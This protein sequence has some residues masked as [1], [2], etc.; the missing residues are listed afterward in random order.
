MN[1]VKVE[2]KGFFERFWFIISLIVITLIA[3]QC[4]RNQQ[5]VCNFR[6][7]I[8][9]GWGLFLLYSMIRINEF[10][11]AATKRSK[12][13]G[14]MSPAGIC[15]IIAILLLVIDII[16]IKTDI[17]IMH[18]PTDTILVGPVILCVCERLGRM[19]ITVLGGKI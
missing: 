2:N 13:N 18:S 12:E 16:L 3:N 9:V 6:I 11:I 1:T 10:F 17:L 5:W 8:L 7:G 14:T 15:W 19:V 4:D